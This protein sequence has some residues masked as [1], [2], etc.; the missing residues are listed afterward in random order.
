MRIATVEDIVA[1]EL[2]AVELELACAASIAAPSVA[3]CDRD[4]PVA[5][6]ERQASG[7]VRIVRLS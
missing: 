3:S 5:L 4:H 7:I 1:L 2:L 6:P